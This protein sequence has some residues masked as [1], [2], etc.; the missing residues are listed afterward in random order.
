MNRGVLTVGMIEVLVQRVAVI[1][2]LFV[3]TGPLPLKHRHLAIE[4]FTRFLISHT[5]LKY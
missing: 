4:V 2:P 1:Q 5:L 3:S